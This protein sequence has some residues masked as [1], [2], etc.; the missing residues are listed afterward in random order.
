[1]RAELIKLS[2]DEQVLVM[3][4]H[5]IISDGWSMG[6]LVQ[7]VAQCYEAC[8]AGR[9]ARL[10]ELPIQYAD[11]AYWQ[12]NWLQ[13]DLLHS[14]LDYWKRQLENIPEVLQ[15]PT[16]RPRPVLRTT[17]GAHQ[18]L[19]L[20]WQLY[21]G[22]KM[23]GRGENTTLYMTILA[24][25]QALLYR[26][27]GQDDISVGTP[28]ANRNRVEIEELIGFFVNT[29]VMRTR[30]S[31]GESFRQLLKQVREVALGAYA[32]QD[33]PFERLV[34]ELQP[35]RD[36]SRSPLFQVM[37]ILQNIPMPSLTLPD[38]SLTPWEIESDTA[39]FD[40][41]LVMDETEKGLV[42]FLS[43]NI[44][45]FDQTTIS[46]MLGH[47]ETLLEGII[48]KPDTCIANLPLLSEAERDQLLIEWNSTQS[49]YPQDK[50]VHELFEAQVECT[51][52][53]IAVVFQDKQYSYQELNAHANKLA[54][55]LRKIVVGPETVVGICLNCSL[56]MIISVL[57]VLKAGGAY[58]PLDPT[59]PSERLAFLIDDAQV[60]VLITESSCAESLP[61]HQAKTIYLDR[62]SVAIALESPANLVNLAEPAN[63]AYLIYT[64]GSTGKP[65]GTL[66]SHQGLCN[67][68]IAQSRAFELQAS[69]H[70][71][72][73]ASLSF[74]ASV[75]EI[76]ITLLSGASLYLAERTELMPGP[77]L[78]SLL[79]EEQISVVTLPPT[80]LAALAEEELPKLQTIIVAGEACTT[81]LVARWREGRRFY[82]AYGP[83]E[84]TVCATIA[85]CRDVSRAAIGQPIANTEIYILDTQMQA[86]P[87]G[88]AGELHIGGIGLAR[89]Y[90]NRPE[91]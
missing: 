5:H 75:S 54:R 30:I 79:R 2:E 47:L 91:L 31:N 45:L 21:N 85:E 36:L 60:S 41:S 68:A 6:V 77:G 42:G 59:Y 61:I 78:L 88:V 44:D 69:D 74:D 62:D 14:Q 66:L 52:Q 4:M 34:E 16:D 89:G 53:A 57:G 46:R 17:R 76:F 23:L 26:Y 49:D 56:D 70:I 3:V 43:Y 83:T 35:E 63:L 71:L 7:E 8:I 10:A 1:I 55:Y 33:I 40:L 27:T 39:K 51:P 18:P 50:C 25:F 24:A 84:S 48:A 15:L 65:K 9:T 86:V 81:E 19:R 90:L 37:L 38:L 32:H 12:R 22:L 58:L 13:G 67:L 82:N 11:Y 64:S 28:I 72:Q 73:F 29:L 80:V 87:I 20:S